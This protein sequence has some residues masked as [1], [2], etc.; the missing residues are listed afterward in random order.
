MIKFTI[1]YKKQMYKNIKILKYFLYI[2]FD[3]IRKIINSIFDI[4][5]ELPFIVKP[6]P[7]KFF[8]NKPNK[9]NNVY[10]ELHKNTINKKNNL[11]DGFEKELGF[12][13]DKKWF[14]DVSLVTQTCIKNHELNFNHGRIL[15]SLLCKYIS[16][17]KNKDQKNISI[18]E[19]GT[20]RGFSSL[21]MS[22]A[23]LDQKINGKIITIDCIPHEKKMYWNSISD[24][25][26]KKTRADLLSRWEDELLNIIFIQGWT[27]DVLNKLAIKRI[28]FAFLDAQH[29]KESVLKEFKYIYKRQEKGDIIFFDDV[30]PNH[31]DFVGVC[32]AVEEIENN[33]PYKIRRIDFDKKRNYALAVKY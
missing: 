22:R 7:K 12:K 5:F 10:L 13:I 2:N 15:Y 6:F 32:E 30:T 25:E 21:C 11:L 23:I 18:L 28:N 24:C 19:T 33:Y 1:K 3:N 31:I 4:F 9:N 17:I 16:D 8:S 29:T 27:L 20:A 14:N 26:G